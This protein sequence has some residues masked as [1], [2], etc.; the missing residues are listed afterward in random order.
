MRVNAG[1]ARF[2]AE[3]PE[4]TLRAGEALVRV[5][6]CA[7]GGGDVPGRGEGIPGR[8]F[9]GVVERVADGAREEAW[10]GRRVVASALIAC[11]RCER[12]RSGLSNHCAGR[13]VLGRMGCDGGA[14]ERV[15]VPVRNLAEVPKG[16][17]DEVAV[18]AEPL[19]H[20]VHAAG[21]ARVEGRTYVTVLGDGCLAL[22]CAQ[23]MARRNASVRLLGDRPGRLEL[24]EKWGIKHRL[25]GETGRRQDQ[26]LVFEC[27]GLPRMIDLAT[28]FVRPRGTVVLAAS[29]EGGPPG[30]DAAAVTEH[31][32]TVLGCRGGRIAGGLEALTA[33][34]D[35]VSL[36]GR[37]F[38]LSEG[39]SA[40]RV[41]AD[42]A[43]VRVLIEP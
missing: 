31:E 38:R 37:R 28:R 6:R 24:C 39:E 21:M 43:C 16:V 8:E 1:T 9:V 2:D 29:P 26:E 11:G 17:G 30:L 14:A 33:G 41:A 5:L 13:R 4:P 20:A 7:L 15:A 34:V 40:A 42:P 27:S 3:C 18:F 23:V 32:L 12:C 22:L 10:V 19:S 25:I 35:V 36:I